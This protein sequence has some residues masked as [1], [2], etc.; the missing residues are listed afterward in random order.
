MFESEHT[1]KRR[2][3]VIIPNYSMKEGIYVKN[4]VL[5]FLKK[6]LFKGSTEKRLKSMG[7]FLI[8]TEYEII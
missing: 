1:H 8:L 4:I 3:V 6:W 2:S 5:F 7:S